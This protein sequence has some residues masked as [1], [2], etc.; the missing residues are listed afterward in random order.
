MAVVDRGMDRQ[1]LD[2]GDAEPDEVVDHRRRGEAGEGA[3]MLRID[4]GMNHRDPAHVQLENDRL[5]PR[6]LRP[7]LL[8]PGKGRLDDPAFGDI[9][10]IVAPVDRQILARAAER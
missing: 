4:A 2:R 5:F 1:Q 7:V 9:A 8:A 10:R 6:D 3:A